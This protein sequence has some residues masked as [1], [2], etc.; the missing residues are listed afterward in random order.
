[1]IEHFGDDRPA[2]LVLDRRHRLIQ[3]DLHKLLERVVTVLAP[4]PPIDRAAK[5]P[6]P[7]F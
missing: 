1:L 6:A 3:L 7:A 2:E 4:A 5:R